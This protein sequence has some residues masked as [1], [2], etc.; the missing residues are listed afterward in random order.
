MS[1]RGT[2]EP[3]RRI[4]TGPGQAV[5]GRS[6]ALEATS[7]LSY[8]DPDLRQA[9]AELVELARHFSPEFTVIVDVTLKVLYERGEIFLVGFFFFHFV[10][11]INGTNAEPPHDTHNCAEQKFGEVFAEPRHTQAA[12]IFRAADQTRPATVTTTVAI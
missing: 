8:V 7:D 12:L 3:S 10:E 9:L 1:S 2:R 4:D 6:R 11:A 5:D